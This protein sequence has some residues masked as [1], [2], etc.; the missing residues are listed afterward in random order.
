VQA[1]QQFDQH[2]PKP[3]K[4]VITETFHP[5]SAGAQ[6]L[7]TPFYPQLHRRPTR[8][9]EGAFSPNSLDRVDDTNRRHRALVLSRIPKLAIPVALASASRLLGLMD[10]DCHPQA[11]S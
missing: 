5:L 7:I 8:P 6:A 11:T 1:T 2:R 10:H 3:P 4:G 9:L